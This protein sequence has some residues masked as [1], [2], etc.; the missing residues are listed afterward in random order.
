MAAGQLQG[1]QSAQKA[2]V[3]ALIEALKLAKGKRVNIYTDSAYAFGAAHVELSQWKRA[4]F[5]TAGNQPIK[6]EEEMRELA[7]VLMQ[8]KEVAFIKCRGHDDSGAKVARGNAEA[9]KAAKQA[10]G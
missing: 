9:D 2:E 1:K 3:R 4:G 8:P 5:V 7:E 10:A 6:H